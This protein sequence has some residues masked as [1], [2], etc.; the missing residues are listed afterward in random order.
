MGRL[1]E[2]FEVYERR[3]FLPDEVRVYAQL[4]EALPIG[5]GQTNSQPYTV[6]QML[7]WLDVR[8]GQR[9]LDVGSGS[10][11][12]TAL[13]SHLVGV[14]G[15]VYAVERVPELV[16]M[17]RENNDRAGVENVRF[18]RAGDEYG[19]PGQGPFDRILVSAGADSLP[20]EL[21][22]QLRTPG[23][24]VIPIA[25]TIYEIEKLENGD[26]VQKGHEGFVFVPL[27]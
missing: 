7:E 27:I 23:K 15:Y 18:Y 6:R 21:M 19:L 17:G 22:D 10:G 11:W 26:I 3:Q 16:E 14:N 24:M 13:L 20:Q 4:D 1:D 5:Y 25:G 9:V 2:A 12:T 8:E